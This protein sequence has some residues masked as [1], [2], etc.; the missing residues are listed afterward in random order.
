ML[1]GG[2]VRGLDECVADKDCYQYCGARILLR[3]IYWDS[4]FLAVD[5]F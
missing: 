3:S 1:P 5:I 4:S 2:V